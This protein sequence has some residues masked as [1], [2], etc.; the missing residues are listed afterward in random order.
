MV[1]QVVATGV[2]P[3]S[4]NVSPDGTRVVVC[5]F[6][7]ADHDNVFVYDAITLD[8][9]RRAPRSPATR[10]RRCS[11]AM[12]ATLYVSNFRAACGRRCSTSPRATPR[13]RPRLVRRRRAPRSAPRVIPSSW[14][15]RPTSESSTSPTG[16]PAAVSVVDTATFQELRRLPTER[17]PRGLVVRPDG[18]LLAAAFDGNVI[19][20]FPPNATRESARWETCDY[21]RH[22]LLSPD[23]AT[24]YVTCSLGTLGFY[25]ANTG[26]RFG[27]GSLHRNP[28]TIDISHDGRWVA[29][30]NFGSTPT[31]RWST[32]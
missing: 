23:A 16:A 4:V 5:N 6:G 1:S 32:R 2:Q 17:H 9:R 3:K 27:I 14:R 7:F 22:L 31:S 30:A 20:V 10:S 13:P 29:S 19:H 11:P 25:D 26:R 28:R 18:T 21:P 24:L 12:A 15:S 8:R